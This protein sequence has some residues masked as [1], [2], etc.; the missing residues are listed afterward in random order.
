MKETP[1]VA[2][3][4]TGYPAGRFPV[5]RPAGNLA[6]IPHTMDRAPDGRV[7]VVVIRDTGRA[8]AA[9]PV[10]DG[11]IGGERHDGV[12]CRQAGVT[13][14]PRG[15]VLPAGTQPTSPGLRAKPAGKSAP[16]YAPV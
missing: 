13:G 14:K 9:I 2:N 3:L 8:P 4:R 16:E 6:N 1:L 12:R 7:P 11:T 15:E 10:R 5:T